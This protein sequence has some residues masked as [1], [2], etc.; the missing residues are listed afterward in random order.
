MDKCNARKAVQGGK[1]RPGIGV[2][3]VLDRYPAGFAQRAIYPPKGFI[4]DPAQR[5]IFRNLAAA[6]WR[7]LKIGDMPSLIGL[8]TRKRS[9]ASILS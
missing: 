1:E 4:H 5:V 6:G 9:Y 7:D 3:D 2:S 8:L